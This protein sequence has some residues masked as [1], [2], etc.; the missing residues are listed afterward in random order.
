M[1]LDTAE[2]QITFNAEKQ[3]SYVRALV[4][5]VGTITFFTIDDHYIKKNLSHFLLVLI[6][7]YGAFVLYFKP[8]EKYP[9]FLASWF[10]Y[11]SDCFFATIWIYATGGFFSPYYVMLYTSI[12]AVAYRFDLKTTLFTSSLYTICYFMLIW[13][14]DQM[15]GHLSFVLV[16]MSFIFIIGFFAN[17]ITKET[18]NQTAQKLQMQLLAEESQQAEKRLAESE[19]RLAALNETLRLKNNIYSHAEENALL[20][21]YSLN[22]ENGKLEYSDNLFRL[23]GHQP[24]DFQPTFEKYFSFIHPDEQERIRTYA[25]NTLKER[26]VAPAFFRAVINGEI[27]HLKITGK[28]IKENNEEILVGTVQDVTEDVLMQQELRNK[29]FELEQM[30]EQLASFNYIASHDLQEPV[31]KIQIFSNL[32]LEKDSDNLSEKTKNYL[33]RISSAGYRMQN[34]I[35]AFLN[36]SKISNAEVVFEKTDLNQLME[37]VKT[38]IIDLIHEKNAVIEY[39]ELPVIYAMPFQFQQLFVNLISN[40][41]KYSKPDVHPHI[42][43]TSKMVK[44]SSLKVETADQ[45]MNYWKLTVEDNGIGFDTRFSNK[46]FEVFQRLHAKDNY[47][48]SGVGLAIC[49][50]VVETHRGFIDVA[51]V[52]GEGSAFNIYIPVTP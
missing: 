39:Q 50:K 46:I 15:E 32:I 34:L 5:L 38:N 36:Y 11:I 42:R 23:L 17:L 35:L 47:G 52:I 8:Y 18:L 10:T 14:L 41:I 29:N 19:V 31:R 28:T 26:S 13:Y 21:S 24:G 16:R 51:S 43:I 33:E 25:E 6:W 40:S 12:I 3:I 30:N 48:G 2:K 44:G 4:I 22:F 49:K 45:E 7:L 37:E 1:I 9:I 27:K 20:G